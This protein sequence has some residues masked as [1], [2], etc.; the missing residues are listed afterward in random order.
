M[1][2]VSGDGAT[3]HLGGNQPVKEAPRI[4]LSE[5]GFFEVGRLDSADIVI[6][7][8]SVSGLHAMIRVGANIS[9]HVLEYLSTCY[10]G[11]SFHLA[12]SLPVLVPA[13]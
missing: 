5:D 4:Q 6:P 10:F 3:Q 11:N 1:L 2:P 9:C 8:P 7:I 12:V 13:C